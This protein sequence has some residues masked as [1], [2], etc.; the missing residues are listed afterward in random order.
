MTRPAVLFSRWPPQPCPA[1]VPRRPLLPS[2]A[3]S[4][5]DKGCSGQTLSRA[6]QCRST[7]TICTPLPS[8]LTPF[9]CENTGAYLQ[10]TGAMAPNQCKCVCV[11]LCMCARA[12]VERRKTFVT[13]LWAAAG[14][15]AFMHPDTLFSIRKVHLKD[16]ARVSFCTRWENFC[17]Y[18]FRT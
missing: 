12:L 11:C 18:V 3:C 2:E 8:A 9:T 15:D 7:P 10:L 13:E 1:L 4:S 14:S 17:L 5:S 16:S 6:P